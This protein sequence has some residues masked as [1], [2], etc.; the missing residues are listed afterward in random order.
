[1]NI[2]QDSFLKSLHFIFDSTTKNQ[3]A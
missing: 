1:M 2:N 3:A